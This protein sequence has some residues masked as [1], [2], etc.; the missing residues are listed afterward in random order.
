MIDKIV[1]SQDRTR[2]VIHYTTGRKL[3][4]YHSEAKV[5]DL[6]ADILKPIGSQIETM[7][8]LLMSQ[9]DT[10]IIDIKLVS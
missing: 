2:A 6:I 9:C 7:N 8:Q 5:A 4:L 10:A 3:E 1:M